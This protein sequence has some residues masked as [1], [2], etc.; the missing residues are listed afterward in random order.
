[1]NSP[2]EAVAHLMAKQGLT[3]EQACGIVGSLMALG[4]LRPWHPV[5]GGFRQDRYDLLRDW[6][7]S[8]DD[9]DPDALETQLDF[10][11]NELRI[12]YASLGAK[13]D[14]DPT[15]NNAVAVMT[16]YL[17]PHG[18]PSRDDYVARLQNAEVLLREMR[19]V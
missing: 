12:D 16:R 18:S 2:Q 9:R 4:D 6:A 15:I 1:M 5:S 17:H 10:L 13:L 7:S 19:G 8:H 14:A 3:K 11:L